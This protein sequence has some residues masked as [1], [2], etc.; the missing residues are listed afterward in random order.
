[1]KSKLDFKYQAYKIIDK[2]ELATDTFLF[3]L[4][5]RVDFSPGQF[6]QVALDHYGEATF[7]P[8]SDPKEKKF[9]ELC[10]RGYGATTGQINKLL[11]GDFLKVRGPYGNGWPIAKLIGKNVLMIAGGLGLV[12]LRPL[13]FEM[14]RSKSEFKKITLVCGARS[15]DQILFHSDLIDWHK[16]ISVSAVVEHKTRTFWGEKGMITDP[17]KKWSRCYNRDPDR[18]VGK[19]KT[20]LP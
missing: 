7:A 12:P 1:M 4:R 5:G 3:R 6:V 20:L 16:K 9:F 10:V 11:P 18:S 13:I 14:I 8:C 15:D 19:S 2:E 17:L